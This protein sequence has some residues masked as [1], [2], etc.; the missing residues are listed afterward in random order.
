[1]RTGSVSFPDVAEAAFG[2]SGRWVAGMLA[3]VDLFA[4]GVGCMILTAHSLQVL[5]YDQDTL[6][7]K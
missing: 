1:M 3:Y 7:A 4:M 6:S 5:R 2:P